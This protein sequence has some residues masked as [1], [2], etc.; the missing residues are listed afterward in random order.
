[1]KIVKNGKLWHIL[2]SS[3]PK[4]ETFVLEN[5]VGHIDYCLVG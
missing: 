3:S 1:M 5:Q 2:M 4:V